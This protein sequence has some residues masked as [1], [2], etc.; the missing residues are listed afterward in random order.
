MVRSGAAEARRRMAGAGY[1]VSR[2]KALN[3]EFRRATRD[4]LSRGATENSRLP[5][6]R[7]RTAWRSVAP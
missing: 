4:G 1:F 7:G 3:L 5:P 6:L 2:C